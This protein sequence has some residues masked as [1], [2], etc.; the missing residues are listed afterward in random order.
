MRLD[1]AL[2][3][4]VEQLRADGRSEH[5][6]RQYRRHVRLLDRWL[7]GAVRVEDITHEDLARFLNTPEAR[8]RPDGKPK[9]ATA[10]NALRSS[11]RTF[12]AYAH[13][14]GLT[15]ANPGRLIRRARCAPP[16]PR[17]LSR[18]EQ[19][20]L[21]ATLDAA[22]GDEAERDR[23]LFHVM[24]ATGIRV[25][26]ALALDVED[27]DLER[28]EL[29]LRTTKGDRPMP[30]FFNRRIG[31][32]LAGQIRDRTSGPLFESRHGLR[33]SA[34]QV[35]RRLGY[36]LEVAGCR[37]ASPHGLRHT[38]ATRLYRQ[39]GDVL[40]VKEALGHRSIASTMVY[41][42]VSPERLRATVCGGR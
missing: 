40:L 28:G 31:D 27:V 37:R 24:L 39:T 9:K 5:T 20:R 38:F 1:H 8:N 21:L 15:K 10:T 19:E 22:E 11:L 2:N 13:A 33:L 26:S 14:A 3:L 7:G 23:V 36:W 4:Y 18:D 32:L 35:Q 25:G 16:P 6:V 17:G 29:Y 42:Q 41:A 30:V 12:F 34:R